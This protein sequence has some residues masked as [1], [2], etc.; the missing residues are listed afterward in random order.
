MLNAAALGRLTSFCENN[1]DF[2]LLHGDLFGQSATRLKWS[3]SS[4]EETL[5]L[6]QTYQRLLR[7]NQDRYV[8]R[9][10]LEQGYTSASHIASVPEHQFLRDTRDVFAGDNNAASATYR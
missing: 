3:D 9:Q 6:V 4:V 10:L 7:V 2:D 1:P 8:A 5:P